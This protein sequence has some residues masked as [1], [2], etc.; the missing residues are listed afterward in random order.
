MHTALRCSDA[1]AESQTAQA[2]DGN[3]ARC[4]DAIA[5]S[6]TEQARD[7]NE[8]HWRSSEMKIHDIITSLPGSSITTWRV[9][10]CTS[11]GRKTMSGA[12]GNSDL[13][14]VQRRPLQIELQNSRS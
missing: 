12:L 2:S 5:E 11:S 6:E 9:D 4:S 7:G 10:R 14:C 1:I 13:P 8:V 3:E